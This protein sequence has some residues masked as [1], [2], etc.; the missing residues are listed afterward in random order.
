MRLRRFI[1]LTASLLTLCCTFAV[2]GAEA[3]EEVAVKGVQTMNQGHGKAF[4]EN[5]HTDLKSS[6]RNLM[7]DRLRHSPTSAS[8]QQTLKKY[9][10]ENLEELEKLS[11]DLFIQTTIHQM[12]DSIPQSMRAVLEDATYKVISSELAGDT[13]RVTVEANC[14]RN[15]KSDIIRM[16]L[17]TKREADIWKYYGQSK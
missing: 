1:A 6:M 17:L 9:R 7:L 5:A 10:V 11:L 15:G 2:R 12:H 16:I 3:W 4:A 8:T 13:Y 14:I